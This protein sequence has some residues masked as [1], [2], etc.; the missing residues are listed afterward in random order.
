MNND[1]K[2]EDVIR[3]VQGLL[4]KA[5]SSGFRRAAIGSISA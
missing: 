1:K 2:R 3:K 4:D 5:A